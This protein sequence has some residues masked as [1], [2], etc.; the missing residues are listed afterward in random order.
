MWMT[1]GGKQHEC[2]YVLKA[3][4]SKTEIDCRKLCCGSEF[5]AS[6]TGSN[7]SSNPD[8]DSGF[9]WPKIEK[10]TIKK[11]L[12][13]LSTNAFY[14]SLGLHEGRPRFRRSLQPRKGNIQM[15]FINFFLFFWVI[16]VLLEKDQE[17]GSGSKD[18][19]ESG[20]NRIQNTGR[21]LL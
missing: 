12:P 8:P 15:K 13:F 20:S 17:C 5:T 4:L 10:N 7:I 21:K 2:G 11:N 18:P 6:G 19:T 16:F 3:F 9:C 1:G 14:L